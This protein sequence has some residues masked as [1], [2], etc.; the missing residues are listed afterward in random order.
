M[1]VLVILDPP[2]ALDLS[3]DTSYALMLEA[4]RRGHEVWTCQIGDLGLEHDAPI[5]DAALTH[6]HAAHSAADAF[7]HEPG[8]PLPLDAFDVVLMR[9]DPPV[10]T[11][12]LLATWQLERVRG[13]TMLINDPRGLGELD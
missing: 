10:D 13:S 9:K 11:A 7:K 2:E 8:T 6:V 12:Y 5:A 4:S 1:R 3:G